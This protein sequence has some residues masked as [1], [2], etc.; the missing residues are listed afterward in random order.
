VYVVLRNLVQAGGEQER[1]EVM[2]FGQLTFEQG[3][4]GLEVEQQVG[5]SQKLILRWWLLIRDL[6]RSVIGYC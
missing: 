5:R 4:H 1:I 2:T 3:G 6:V